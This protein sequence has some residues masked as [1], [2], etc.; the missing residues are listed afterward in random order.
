MAAL[1]WNAAG[2]CCGD[3]RPRWVHA[4]TDTRRD[5]EARR[6]MAVIPVK[7]RR[8][9]QCP[10]SGA[11]FLGAAEQGRYV[12]YV[13]TFHMLYLFVRPSRLWRLVTLVIPV[14]QS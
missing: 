5:T 13:L 3:E 6:N 14:G 7:L 4:T 11:E 9:A 12:Q 1:E 2:W 10:G 8:S